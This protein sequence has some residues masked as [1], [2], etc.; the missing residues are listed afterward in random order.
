VARNSIRYAGSQSVS[1]SLGISLSIGII[2][3]NQSRKLGLVV[4]WTWLKLCLPFLCASGFLTAI[5][6]QQAPP[7]VPAVDE[8]QLAT[9]HGTV[10]PLARP[11]YDQGTVAEEFPAHRLLLMMARPAD[12]ER[13]L[14]KLLRDVHAPGSPAYHQWVSPEEFGARFGATDQDTQLVSQWLQAHGLSV[15]RITKG[16]SILE[17]SGTARQLREALHTEIHQYS[18]QGKTYYANSSEIK[19]PQSIASRIAAFAPLNSFPLDSYVKVMG[20][21]TMNRASHRAIPQF[22]INENNAPFY[23]FG[24]E[25]FATQYDVAPVYTAGINGAGQTIGIIGEN[26]LNLSFVDAYRKLFNLPADRTQVIIDGQDPG[27]GASPNV[28]GYLDVEMSGAVAPGATVN[29]YIAGAEA[30]STQAWNPLTLAALR[31]IEDNQASV[32]SA[33][34]GTCELALGEQG[35]QVWASLWEQAAAQGQTVFVSSGDTGPTTCQLIEGT[36]PS[37]QSLASVNVNGLSSTP[38]NVSVGGT[39]FYYSDYASGAPSAATLWNQTNDGSNGSLKATLPEQVWDD[40]LGFDVVSSGQNAAGGGGVSSCSQETVPT[41][42]SLPTCLAGYPKPAWQNAPGVPSDKARDLPDV[43]LFASN[44]ANLSAVPLCAEPGDCATVTSG[45]PQITLVGGTSASSPS[46]AGIMALID[47]KYGRQGQANY[48]LYAL[49]RQYPNVFHDITLGTNDVTCSPII[50]PPDCN[51]PVPNSYLDSYGIYAAGP[52]YDMASGLGSVDVNQLLTN[53]NKVTYAAS[54]TT[55]QATPASIVHGSAVTVSVAVKA[56]SGSA[57]PTGDVELVASPGTTIPVNSPLTLASASASASPTN[58]PGGSY[59]LTAQYEGDGTFAASTSAPI[60]LTV[61]PEASATGLTPAYFIAPG[62]NPLPLGDIPYGNQVAFSAAPSSLATNAA[63]L[64][65]GTVT[66]T[67]GSTTA[68]VP[69]DGTGIATWKPRS[70]AMGAHSIT[71]AYSGDASYQ[72]STSKSLSLTVVGVAPVLQVV[73]DTQFSGCAQGLSSCGTNE[74]D[75][76]QPGS[77]MVLSVLMNGG[78]G[79]P[80]TGTVTVNFGSLTQTVSLATVSGLV[81]GLATFADVPAGSY[82]LSASYSGDANWSA[83]TFTNPSPFIFATPPFTTTPTTTTLTLSP[84][85]ADSTQ[86]VTFQVTS[87][88]ASSQNGCFIGT[89]LAQ[90]YAN[91]ASFAAVPVNC[92]IVNGVVALSG[93]ATIPASELPSGTYQVV[94]GYQGDGIQLSSFSSPV[95]L[96]VTVTDFSLGA[97]GKN[98]P[99]ATG[100]SLTIPVA[101]DGPSS[102]PITIALSCLTSSPSIG[103]TIDPSSSSVTGNGT[104]TL[105]VNAFTSSAAASA[106]QE[107]A[108]RRNGVLPRYAEGLAFACLVIVVLPSRRRLAK[109]WSVLVL[110]AIFSITAGCGSSHST[111]TTSPTGPTITP[112]AAGSYSVTVTGI[113]GGITHSSTVN[114]QVQ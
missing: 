50:A 58:L 76:Y 52:G 10:H 13:D 8:G 19:L 22:T 72:A 88:A 67:D 57:V 38:W 53:W 64:A 11:E 103:C 107:T 113:S 99:V 112:A 109:L 97:L 26:N 56:N 91:G 33:S 69:L 30:V 84:S 82:L 28:E 47:Q 86:S 6:A 75:I 45:D 60:S 62:S 110:L 16:K 40:A 49:A 27:D 81:A 42:G 93:S 89:S 63:G 87:H 44:G 102:A 77:N 90:L 37:F 73:P 96:T 9:L 17:F 41:I 95:S 1:S 51:T 39:D 2:P 85:S 114:L 100:K 68:T 54:T 35:N 61:M 83:A 65:T 59:E 80:P 66:F 46:M 14:Q 25:D 111:M 29:F 4:N 36:F 70:F 34:F 15:T 71:A 20:G 92:S 78:K 12:R 5:H 24:P 55:L 7:A 43:S 74:G 94:A 79:V 48:T 21:A 104:A 23:A 108:S 3:V 106:R 18:I 98:L 31:A 32:L 101:L 105:T